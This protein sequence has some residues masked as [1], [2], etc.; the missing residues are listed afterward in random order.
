MT[1]V[2]KLLSVALAENGYLEKKTNSQL[3]NKTAN[4]G[5]NN[6]NKYARDLDIMGV[7]NGKKNGYSWCDIFVDWCFITSFGLTKGLQMLFQPKGGLGAG[8]TYSAKYFK[9]NGRLFYSN[10]QPGDQ[11]FFTKDG[12]K[13]YYHTGIFV[14]EENGKYYTIEGNTSSAPGVEPNGG[15]V[16]YKSYSKS[17]SYIGAF[18]RPNWG[19]IT[20][21]DLGGCEM[22]QA[23]F[24]AMYRT[25][26]KSMQDND[27]GTWSKD[28][29][30]WAI[31]S[32]LVNGTGTTINGQPN[33]AWEDIVTREQDVVLFKRF[34]EILN[35]TE[36]INIWNNYRKSLQT[37][38]ASETS[39]EAREWAIENGLIAGIGNV[40][41]QP[42]YAWPD[43]TSREQNI[44]LF[45]RFFNFMVNYIEDH[46]IKG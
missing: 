18:G 38:N 27:A 13:T 19:L 29:R 39:E 24:E 36:F 45:Y 7:Y 28:A 33:Y 14:K 22:T 26:R 1:A 15:A 16:R 32:G 12:R 8:C 2:E 42:N 11:I 25:M 21:S 43:F 5:Y 41:G 46:Y 35:D 44:I 9:D 40:N 17:Y 37:N 23:E 4:A 20:D 10:P 6:W 31:K 3:D 30:D 34:L